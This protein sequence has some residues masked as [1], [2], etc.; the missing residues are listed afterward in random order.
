VSGWVAERTAAIWFL[1]VPIVTAIFRFSSWKQ[2]M[3]DQAAYA[4]AQGVAGILS[5]VS[6]LPLDAVSVED[7]DALPIVNYVWNDDDDGKV[8]GN[9]QQSAT[10]DKAPVDT[11]TESIAAAKDTTVS[12]S[13]NLDATIQDCPP[14]SAS[15]VATN[16]LATAT[17]D[18]NANVSNASSSSTVSA[19]ND[20]S[21]V[22]PESTPGSSF[23]ATKPVTRHPAFQRPLVHKTYVD[24]SPPP[25]PKKESPA[26]PVNTL[27]EG[28][29]ES[30]KAETDTD[31]D[32]KL[33]LDVN[34]MM[35]EP[36]RKLYESAHQSG[37]DQLIIRLQTK[38]VYAAIYNL[39]CIPYVS[40]EVALKNPERL[41]QTRRVKFGQ[42]GMRTVLD[43]LEHD[44]D[45]KGKLETTVEMQVLISCL[46]S[47][48]VL[49]R[50]TGAVLQ[51]SADGLLRE[52]T[53]LVRFETT[54]VQE[55]K[56]GRA[57]NY[58]T[59]WKITD[60]DD[61][62]GHVAWYQK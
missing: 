10:K 53:H 36:L 26:P 52:V 20:E 13:A 60:I 23:V 12:S 30:P 39:M 56:D 49:D 37:R 46:E 48:Q 16:H 17:R 3:A 35:I 29:M 61:M 2:N 44:L 7:E 6:Q 28:K 42:E 62:L 58:Y 55:I 47:F 33:D 11:T 15:E 54:S 25:P 1:N 14:L 51:G 40:R 27:T 24:P 34:E 50:E 8:D 32:T 59:N 41:Q 57:Q 21:K 45:E 19:T 4:F 18:I 22:I 9:K 38:P 5:N 31:I 43:N